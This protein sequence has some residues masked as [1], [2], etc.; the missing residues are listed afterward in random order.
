MKL[1]LLFSV[2]ASFEIQVFWSDEL[3]RLHQGSGYILL[4][5]QRFGV[6]D[7]K[8]HPWFLEELPDGALD[9]NNTLMQQ[10]HSLDEVG[11]LPF[12]VLQQQPEA[13]GNDTK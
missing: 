6:A 11:N 7:I 9:M 12:V 10:A 5:L 4:L 8:Q 13:R 3:L 1:Y 2:V